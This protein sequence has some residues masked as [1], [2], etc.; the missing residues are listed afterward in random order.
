VYRELPPPAALAGLVECIWRHELSE[1]GADESGIVLPD[2]R[3]DVVWTADGRALVA[4]PQTTFVP[5]P[6]AP[7]FLAVGARFHPGVGPPL[8]GL[9]A[10]E[11][12]DMHVPLDAID[13]RPAAALGDRLAAVSDPGAAVEALGAALARLA[14]A[15]VDPLVR[16]ATRLLDRSQTT[17]AGVASELALSERQLQR[18]LRQTVGYGPKTLQ[19]VLRFR[20]FLAELGR[21]RLGLAAIA[22]A[23][24]YADQAH[25]S[26]ES[27][28]LSGRT[29]AQL[30]RLWSD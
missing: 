8:L 5:R 28:E 29:P 20:R 24:G 10:H 12:V 2:G 15:P 14:D 11:L 3:V 26:R 1:R 21:G 9:P 13:T 30:K 23:A 7:P 16:P 4:G 17:V 22:A 6:L 27:R 19:R 18:R 25:L